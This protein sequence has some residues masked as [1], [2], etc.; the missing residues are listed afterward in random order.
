M[1]FLIQSFNL[2]R[3]AKDT[4]YP[5]QTGLHRSKTFRDP[6][7]TNHSPV[8]L[9]DRQSRPGQPILIISAL[10]MRNLKIPYASCYLSL[11]VEIFSIRPLGH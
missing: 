11:N 4:A 6:I 8:D 10:C 5:A 1:L 2:T 9:R 7:D 3:S